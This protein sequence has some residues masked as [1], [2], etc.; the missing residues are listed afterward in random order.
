MVATSRTVS[1]QA[2]PTPISMDLS[3]TAVLVVDMQNDFGAKGG[4]FD[5]AGVDL[6]VIEQ[7]V[8]PIVRIIEGA[9]SA[10][11]PVVYVRT[12]HR[13]DLSDIGRE[14]SRN[15]QM[16]QRLKVGSGMVAP[17]GEPSRL[18]VEGT[19][20]TEML[21]ELAPLSNDIV[22][23][24]TRF[25]GFHAT[26]LDE[27][28]RALNI[29]S[30]IVVGCTTSI[31]VESTI[32]DAVSRDYICVLPADCTGQ[33]ERPGFSIGS[34]EATLGIIERSFGWISS[35]DEILAAIQ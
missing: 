6:S 22:V 23:T 34:H 21:P 5:R 32:R 20:N 1:I 12:A 8:A 33:P 25:S 14:G 4:M 18:L 29:E 17:T 16:C 10:G 7:A 3:K 15:W 35:S 31:C 30:L 24:K 13:S 11:L 28:L 2:R 27:K 19:W 9:R 26:V